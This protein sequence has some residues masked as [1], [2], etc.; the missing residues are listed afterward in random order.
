MAASPPQR[1]TLLMLFASAVLKLIGWRSVLAWPTAPKGILVVYPH[2]SNW[3]FI[4]GLLF[5][6][7]AG[8]PARWIGKHTIFRWPFRGFFQWMGG[9]AVNRHAP[10]GVI[11]A[12]KAEFNRQD[13]MWLAIAPEGTRTR[14]DYWKS[15]FYRIALAAD[16]PLGL[17]F[18]D[19][20]TRTVGVNFYMTP[21][22]D[23]EADMERIRAFYADKRGRVQENASPIQLQ[24]HDS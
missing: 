1:P 11:H 2:T 3:D 4:I 8:L 14:T 19:Y 12:V 23:P 24:R 18:I 5:K 22:G 20:Q 10:S 9:I 7:G 6:F 21:T 15:G 17:A 16:V 13:W